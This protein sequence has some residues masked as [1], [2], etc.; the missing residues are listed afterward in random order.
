M[1]SFSRYIYYI[2]VALAMVTAQ[3]CSNSDLGDVV[4]DNNTVNVSFSTIF[5]TNA[6]TRVAGGDSVDKLFVELYS[7]GVKVGERK[8][9]TVSNHTIEDFTLPLVSGESYTAVFWAQDTD[10]QAYNIDDLSNI[11]ID[12]AE[13]ITLANID[14][15]DAFS[16]RISFTVTPQTLNQSVTLTRPFALLIAGSSNY[17]SAVANQSASLTINKVAT[18]YNAISGTISG[19]AAQTFNYNIDGSAVPNKSGFTMVGAAYILPVTNTRVTVGVSTTAT[20][21]KSVTA[22]IDNIDPNNRYNILGTDLISY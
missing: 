3:A 16:G 19:S 7:N 15:F 6:V 5:D 17:N 2:V 18:A 10:C 13:N 14:S 21:T 4:A 22:F 9:F 8:G 11:T 12:Y 1:K 20:N